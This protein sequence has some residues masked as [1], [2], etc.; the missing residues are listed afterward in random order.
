MIGIVEISLLFTLHR[1]VWCEKVSGNWNQW[2]KFISNVGSSI[3]DNIT[4]LNLVPFIKYHVL[5]HP[6]HDI[7]DLRTR[8]TNYEQATKMAVCESEILFTWCRPPCSKDIMN[9]LKHRIDCLANPI[10][11]RLCDQKHTHKPYR[12]PSIAPILRVAKNVNDPRMLIEKNLNYCAELPTVYIWSIWI[13][14]RFGHYS[15]RLLLW[16]RY[17]HTIKSLSKTCCVWEL[18]MIIS[19]SSLQTIW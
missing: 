9:L 5:N 8:E 2:S 3:I 19:F 11:R 6:Y 12:R 15:K 1:L 7:I 13:I 4:H 10:V 18:N 14:S 16:S 17:W